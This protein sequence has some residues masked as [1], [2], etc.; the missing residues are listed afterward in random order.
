MDLF[1][2]ADDKT[3]EVIH[4]YYGD[5]YTFMEPIILPIPMKIQ[6]LLNDKGEHETNYHQIEQL[7]IKQVK[8]IATQ[9]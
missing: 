7:I 5:D 9:K 4:I 1:C 8:N 3:V 2:G 6:Y